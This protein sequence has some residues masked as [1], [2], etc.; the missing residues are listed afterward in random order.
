ML[1]LLVYVLS[2]KWDLNIILTFRR[3]KFQK[4]YFWI[5]QDCLK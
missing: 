5:Q 3:N 4:K 2:T 1:M